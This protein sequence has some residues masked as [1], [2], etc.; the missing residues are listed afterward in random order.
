VE[1]TIAAAEALAEIGVTGGFSFMYALPGETNED[2]R[3]TFRLIQKLY[4]IHP[5]TYI[6]GPAIFRPYPGNSLYDL[7]VE[8]GL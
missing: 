7:C 2:V 3:E 6:F 4:K 8:Q 1:S 5:D